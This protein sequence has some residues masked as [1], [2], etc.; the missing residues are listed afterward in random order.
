MLQLLANVGLCE[1][2]GEAG[3]LL[4]PPFGKW[5]DVFLVCAEKTDQGVFTNGHARTTIFGAL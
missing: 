4:A 5:V 1:L 2:P 3:R